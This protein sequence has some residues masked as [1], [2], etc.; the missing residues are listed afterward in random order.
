MGHQFVFH[1]LLQGFR[2]YHPLRGTPYPS[3]ADKYSRL[4]D[5]APY[6]MSD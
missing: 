5:I 4:G 3:V 2:V 6:L 1:T